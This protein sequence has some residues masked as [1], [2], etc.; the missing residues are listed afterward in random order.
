MQEAHDRRK[1]FTFLYDVISFELVD[2]PPLYTDLVCINT[3]YGTEHCNYFYNIDGHVNDMSRLIEGQDQ[4]VIDATKFGN[5]SR[6]IN[7]R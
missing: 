6:F 1:R 7:H 3:R 2:F 5:V 4:Y